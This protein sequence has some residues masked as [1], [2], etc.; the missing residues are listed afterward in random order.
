MRVERGASQILFGFLPGQTADLEGRIWKVVHWTDPV[1]MSLDQDAVRGA[2]RGA[3]APWAVSG[4][5]DGL[6]RDLLA[7]TT[8]EVVQLNMDR[9]VLVEPFPQQWRCKTCGSIARTRDARCR[10]GGTSRAQ[11]QFVTYHTCGASNEPRLP[12][13]PIHDAVAVRLPGTA[14]ARELRIFCPQCHRALTPGG[15]PFQPCNCGDGGMAVTVH[16]AAVVFSPHFAV[17]VNPPTRPKPH[18]YAPAV[19]APERSNGSSTAWSR[20]TRPRAT[21]SGRAHREL[22]QAGV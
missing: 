15:L 6:E 11:M 3:I 5:D 2:L 16:R 1:P 22:R 17:L 19:V 8:V 20:T 12:R 10:C 13:C 14:T 4:N 9:G 18:D 21:D 7:R